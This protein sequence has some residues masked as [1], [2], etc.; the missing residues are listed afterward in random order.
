MEG[1]EKMG[2]PA[3][4]AELYK[5][6]LEAVGF[7][8]VEEKKYIW[9]SNRWPKDKKLKELGLHDVLS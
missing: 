8:D 6:Q 5:S 4:S 7:V 9:P 1:C 2:R 3:N